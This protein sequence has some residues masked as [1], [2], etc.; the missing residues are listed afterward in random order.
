MNKNISWETLIK[1]IDTTRCIFFNELGNYNDD[2]IKC[3]FKPSKEVCSLCLQ[4]KQLK[5]IY[6]L[7]DDIYYIKNNINNS[8]Y[9]NINDDTE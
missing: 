8:E 3:H 1:N 9:Q 2:L 6:D 7:A 5:N 4:A